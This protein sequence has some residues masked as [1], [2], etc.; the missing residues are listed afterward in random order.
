MTFF[1]LVF[2]EITSSHLQRLHHRSLSSYSF[3]KYYNQESEHQKLNIANAIKVALMRTQ[4]ISI[5]S[6]SLFQFRYD[7]DIFTKYRDID[8]K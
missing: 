4:C 2:V 8:I 1:N 3:D 5:A 6:I 7:I